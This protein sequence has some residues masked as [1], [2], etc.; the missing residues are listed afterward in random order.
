MRKIP[1]DYLSITRHKFR[2]PKGIGALHAR[3]R[4]P[5]SALIWCGHQER[6]QRGGTES[7]PLIVGLG[8]A[9]E[10]ARKRPADYEKK[11]RPLRGELEVHIVKQDIV[12][13]GAERPLAAAF[14]HSAERRRR[15][16]HR[17]LC[18]TRCAGR[19]RQAL[20]ASKSRRGLVQFCPLDTLAPI[21]PRTKHAWI[22]VCGLK[23]AKDLRI[24][25]VE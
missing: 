20:R 21:H 3:R 16:P 19:L 11:V 4:G 7:V 18:G 12:K 17:H 14:G 9:A 5:F 24:S 15:A 6:N 23:L 2:A 13:H 8:K 10:L 25:I 1:V 22:K